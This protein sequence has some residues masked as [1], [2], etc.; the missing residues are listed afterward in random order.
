M[1]SCFPFM[2]YIF[3]LVLFIITFSLIHTTR[4]EFLGLVLFF[5]VNLI[6]SALLGMDLSTFITE[7][8]TGETK[9]TRWIILLIAAMLIGLI[10]NFTS[11]V[12]TAMTLG[13]L[14]Y[15][16]GAKGQKILFS[17]DS[18]KKMNDIEGLF[19]ATI[20]LITILSFRIYFSPGE[21]AANIFQWVNANIPEVVFNWGHL[22]MSIVVMGLSFAIMNSIRNEPFNERVFSSFAIS[23]QSLFG[24][25]VAIVLLYLS[26]HLFGIFSFFNTP[27]HIE[28]LRS[29][30]TDYTIPLYSILKWLF[31]VI[32]LSM[33]AIIWYKLPSLNTD[34]IKN[35]RSSIESFTIYATGLIGLYGLINIFASIIDR[36]ILESPQSK[37]IMTK[38]L[39]MIDVFTMFISLVGIAYYY[40]NDTSIFVNTVIY[41]QILFIALFIWA[42]ITAGFMGIS[43]NE[44]DPT[45]PTS[46][47]K[48][49]F[50]LYK[51]LQ[52]NIVDAFTIIKTAILS[53]I[54]VLSGITI[55]N[56][57]DIPKINKDKIEKTTGPFATIFTAFVV[58]LLIVVFMSLFNT[59]N[60]QSLITFIVD[61]AAPLLVIIMSC[62]L[63][64]YSNEISLLSKK[65]PITD[66]KTDPK[67]EAEKYLP[68][69]SKDVARSNIFDGNDKTKI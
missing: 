35:F 58:L 62:V 26:P 19:A 34:M 66:I 2:K 24:A 51:I 56:F 57:N 59:S 32:G 11:S 60:I 42:I 67:E 46:G 40:M 20:V 47:L 44:R 16:F 52:V 6:Y 7:I 17:P 45:D 23:F 68:Q 61:Y 5:V 41:D 48:N 37:K 29:L 3:L 65:E 22:L 43:Y 8:I 36:G 12:L 18:R 54:V 33:T 28:W 64:V 13:N 27:N 53:I 21:I 15:K 1:A 55:K 50:D 39:G 25:L 49:I 31:I 69:M 14:K 38:L 63:V 30:N 10:L 4:L 9:A